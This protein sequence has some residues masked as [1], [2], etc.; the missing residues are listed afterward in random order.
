MSDSNK[1]KE[2]LKY[3]VKGLRP[4]SNTESEKSE[5]FDV[6]LSK[7]PKSN[8]NVRYVANSTDYMSEVKEKMFHG[9][10]L[11]THGLKSLDNYYTII[12]DGVYQLA[13]RSYLD[14]ADSKN[15]MISE[16]K[17]I[18]NINNRAMNL[19][20]NYR[21]ISA[22][23]G[24]NDYDTID[25]AEVNNYEL[26]SNEFGYVVEYNGENIYAFQIVKPNT[27][28]YILMLAESNKDIIYKF[29]EEVRVEFIRKNKE[30]IIKNKKIMIYTNY[31]KG[32]TGTGSAHIMDQYLSPLTINGELSDWK[33]SQA[34]NARSFESVYLNP[35][36]K[37][38]LIEDLD[39][40]MDDKTSHWYKFHGIPSKRSY[41]LYGPPGTGK[42]STVKAIAARYNAE[43]YMFKATSDMDDQSAM[44]LIEQI[45]PRSVLLIEDIDT[46]FDQLGNKAN[47][48]QFL[49]FSGLM[50]ILDGITGFDSQIIIM[51]TNHRELINRDS[52]RVGRIDFELEFGYMIGEQI[53][54]MLES[55]YENEDKDNIRKFVQSDKIKK[56]KDLTPVELQE[57]I[58][59]N[60]DD[61]K[62]LMDNFEQILT[63]VRSGRSS[64]KNNMYN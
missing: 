47:S 55:F 45:S 62:N 48:N 13:M 11:K 14:K 41:L 2:D 6:S 10:L 34:I 7:S 29:A 17:Q 9:S 3:P 43:L 21:P 46:L 58:I 19:S 53:Q 20:T 1:V 42:S 23:T 31:R 44:N 22:R 33:P 15:F 59:R 5:E 30:E 49:T 40:Y 57:V 36:K 61:L 38:E 4:F 39:N 35:D 8:K 52:L 64:S 24:A 32:R 18:K 28:I 56:I 37:R 12:L 25:D 54:N 60:K 26:V 63:V 16:K 50:N 27:P 51:T